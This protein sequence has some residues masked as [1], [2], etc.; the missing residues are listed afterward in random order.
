MSESMR[1]ILARCS[2]R[3]VPFTIVLAGCSSGATATT[4][5][6]GTGAPQSVAIAAGDGQTG[7]PGT[8][9]PTHPAVTVK[10]ASGQPVA[11][12]TVLFVVDSGGGSLSATSAVTG[13][14]GVAAAGVWTLGPLEGRNTVKASVGTL[15]PVKLAATAVV[16][17]ASFPTTTIP[18]NGGSVT[19]TTP[20]PLNGFTLAIPSG[21]FASALQVTVSYASSAALP[22]ATGITV[23][24]PII[25]VASNATAPAQSAFTI[26]IPGKIGAGK[27]P[28]VAMVDP[29]E[30]F[31]EA[32]PIMSYDSTGVS[33][34]GTVLNGTQVMETS[35]HGVGGRGAALTSQQMQYA[36]MLV[37][38]SL[39]HTLSY[40]TG[41]LP[42]NDDWEF[43]PQ[44]TQ[45]Y[46]SLSEPGE[47]VS[48]RY[49]FLNQ[50]S[51]GAGPLWGSFEKTPGVP[52]SDAS[53][54]QW[55]AALSL[56]FDALVQSKIAGAGARRTAN[57]ALYDRN[58]IQT[59]AASMIASGKPQIVAFVDANSYHVV[60]AYSWDGPSGTLWTANPDYPGDGNRKT[61][62]NSQGLNCITACLA[63]VGLNHL[64]GYQSQL[65]AE[66]PAVVDGTIDKSLFPQAFATSYGPFVA[67]TS[68]ADTLFMVQ[69]TARLWVECPTCNGSFPTMIPL[70]HGAGGIE[71]QQIFVQDPSGGWSTSGGQTQTGFFM[72][73]S[74]FPALSTNHFASFE[75]GIEA[76][77]LMSSA[78]GSQST[79]GWLG[80]KEYRVVKL[81]PKLTYTPSIVGTTQAVT[82]L[83]ATF[84][85][86]TD[87]GPPLP[88]SLSYVFKWADG[89]A[90]TQVSPLPTTVTHTFPTAG[91]YTVV[92]EIH[93]SA[94][95]TE[96]IAS[97]PVT[98]VNG[99]TW[100]L[101]NASLTSSALPT[102]TN[103]HDSTE[104]T[105]VNTFITGVQQN[106]ASTLIFA[107]VAPG[108]SSVVIEHF[109]AKIAVVYNN[110]L[111]GGTTTVLAGVNCPADGNIGSF[112]M[113]PLGSGG[114]TGLGPI[115]LVLNGFGALLPGGGGA[116]NATM[117]GTG[118]SGTITLT[119]QYTGGS[120]VYTIQFHAVL[121]APH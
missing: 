48:E 121:V 25:T 75:L 114:L 10:N 66:F 116:I 37:D 91:T 30:G 24:S 57:P 29:V 58:T 63:V 39:L 96:G 102:L 84:A 23:A 27:F 1:G 117:A 26:R 86:S 87:G 89:T 35:R 32:L 34:V 19:V 47:V 83:P 28:I 17:G 93:N 69:D 106:P 71:T 100:Q 61:I 76:L 54:I 115:G 107:S 101:D 16:V 7:Q 33:A 60:L 97:L 108:C 88:Q 120:G 111:V 8:A 112:A 59:I 4:P 14:D 22:H 21:A 42:G 113:G 53:G 81:A 36:M 2:R 52:V 68:G 18:T 55:S 103:A 72:D 62:W 46:P 43:P 15:A 51:Q 110:G 9:L 78:T 80:W 11:G 20:G 104:Q 50:R 40:D 74:Q 13:T 49:Y 41:F 6:S 31:L 92:M 90:D 94:N 98:V 67:A 45:V 70:Q 73:L 105:G 118:L 109:P 44:G 95:Q 79:T 82:G 38:S 77:G 65:D 99:P 56:Q 3:F 12:T 119:V 64:I 5:G 85:V